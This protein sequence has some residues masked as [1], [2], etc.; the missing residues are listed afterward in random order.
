LLILHQFICLSFNKIF[1][2]LFFLTPQSRKA[3]KTIRL[4]L[5]CPHVFSLSSLAWMTFWTPPNQVKS[6]LTPLTVFPRHQR[7][8]FSFQLPPFSD[9]S[10]PLSGKYMSPHPNPYG[11]N[12]SIFTEKQKTSK[13]I[14]LSKEK[15]HSCLPWIWLI[16]TFG[17][18]YPASSR[19]P[20]PPPLLNASAIL[21]LFSTLNITY[22]NPDFTP[23]IYCN[24]NWKCNVLFKPR[25]I[26]QSRPAIDPW[27]S[28]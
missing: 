11:W 16:E 27:R 6:I 4:T 22:L 7:P 10:F 23:T 28:Q 2:F 24:L 15:N 13:N 12:I 3:P 19:P 14:E 1:S 21:S 5:A 18:S 26:P 17:W 25:L 9:I 20:H 8:P